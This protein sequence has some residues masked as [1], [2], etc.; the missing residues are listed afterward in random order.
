[1]APP[2]APKAGIPALARRAQLLQQ[3]QKTMIIARMMI[4]AQLSSS[5]RLQKQ[6]FIVATSV[7][8]SAYAVRYYLMHRGGMCAGGE[9]KET[10]LTLTWDMPPPKRSDPRGHIRSAVFLERTENK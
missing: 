3:Q 4:H 5:N 1:M 9:A 2:V 6:L 8:F 10:P 7:H